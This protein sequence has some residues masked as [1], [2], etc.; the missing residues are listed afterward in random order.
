MLAL[1]QKM[2]IIDIYFLPIV[3]VNVCNLV[4]LPY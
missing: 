3:Q 4:N 2:D 1:D